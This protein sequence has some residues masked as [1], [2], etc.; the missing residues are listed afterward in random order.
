MMT[1]RWVRTPDVSGSESGK[2][3]RARGPGS[4][5][6]GPGHQELAVLEVGG[7]GVAVAGVLHVG[8]P[9]KLGAAAARPEL[10][11]HDVVRAKALGGPAAVS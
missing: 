1:S 3:H 7:E 5:A 10:E 4:G 11:R 8:Q 6:E 2:T 9:G